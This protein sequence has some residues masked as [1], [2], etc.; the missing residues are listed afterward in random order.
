M[1]LI[2][3]DP[4]LEHTHGH[5]ALYDRVIGKEA[6]RR[7][8]EVIILGNKRL[9]EDNLDGIPVLRL[10]ETTCYARFSQD[11]LFAAFDDVEQGNRAVFEELSSLPR[12]FFQRT[13][14]VVAHTVSH[15]SL[16]GIVN[17]IATLPPASC[18]RFC[19]FLMLPSGVCL[20][21]DGTPEIAD[22][23][24]A[25]AYREA[26]RTLKSIGHRVL[27]LASGS[28]HARQFSALSNSDIKSHALLTGLD[29]HTPQ[30]KPK[31]N[32][33]LLFAGDAKMNKG[34]GLLPDLV[35]R[36]CPSYPDH[37]F[38]IHAN[39]GP[40]WG[41]ALEVVDELRRISKSHRNLDLRLSA[42]DAEEYTD[43]LASSNVV[44]L[45]YDPEEYRLKSSGVVWEAIASD[46]ILVVPSNTWLDAECAYWEAAYTAYDRAN[47]VSIADAI[48]QT[49]DN[50]PDRRSQ[51][52]SAARRFK[53]GNGIKALFDQ[54]ADFWVAGGVDLL[55]EDPCKFTFGAET[56]CESGWHELE[57]VS[58]SK[59]RWSDQSANVSV[60]MPGIGYWTLELRG[61]FCFSAEQLNGARLLLDGIPLSTNATLEE[62]GRWSLS[63]QF[64]EEE[65][66]LPRRVLTLA[67]DWVKNGEG[68][69]RQLGLLTEALEVRE[70]P[71]PKEYLS[72]CPIPAAAE[73]VPDSTGW[74][75]SLEVGNWHVAVKPAKGC[76]IALRLRGLAAGSENL[77]PRLFVDGQPVPLRMT[78]RQDGSQ[79]VQ[80]VLPSTALPTSGSINI[81]LVLN[82]QAEIL[83]QDVLWLQHPPAL[84]TTS[85]VVAEALTS[86]AEPR[87]APETKPV[88]KAPIKAEH[89]EWSCSGVENFDELAFANL[90]V[91]DFTIQGRKLAD[92]HVKVM[93]GE[94]F[95]ALELRERD[96]GFQLV[97][98]P[99][100]EAIQAD[101]WGSRLTLF[102]GPDGTCTGWQPHLLAAD[103]TG[104]EAF[105][106]ALPNGI[107]ASGLTEEN[108]VAAAR[109]LSS[110]VQP[111]TA[112]E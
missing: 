10:L 44:L 69:S 26:F 21:E 73:E 108:W 3:L 29:E 19:I 100:P 28:Q 9:G 24:A 105:L 63:C 53:G 59:V 68:D 11:T 92:F 22:P 112:A 33:T 88:P 46:S 84:P 57:D 41:K 40:A 14:L 79:Q 76:V 42:L 67:L 99:D 98:D 52:T 102:V 37:E 110:L 18:P 25:T 82:R 4:Q 5:H 96:G 87:E 95:Y 62:D 93:R 7:G 75:Q 111:A 50:L 47:I 39:S 45:P 89:A 90:H 1:R 30:R 107:A 101:D 6:C 106:A 43:L 80:A 55:P 13:D 65:P 15:T 64:N 109:T 23:A 56:L 86:S 58:G 17:W 70:S 81:S 71:V 34:L 51:A 12:E 20:K 38:I 66:D 97:R 77:Q 54:L 85:P 72:S 104:L 78:I 49:F 94:N 8:Q 83:I 60:Q 74:T 91:R 16:L 103:T 32:R 27:L 31:Y 36:L 48:R 2:L 61:P 35:E